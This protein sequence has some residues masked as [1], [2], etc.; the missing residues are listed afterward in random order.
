MT[1]L[2]AIMCVVYVP[3]LFVVLFFPGSSSWS[4][5]LLISGI[6]LIVIQSIDRGKTDDQWFRVSIRYRSRQERLERFYSRYDFSALVALRFYCYFLG[7]A[8]NP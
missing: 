8:E 3:M 5:W 2:H 4:A 6:V 1:Q 7:M